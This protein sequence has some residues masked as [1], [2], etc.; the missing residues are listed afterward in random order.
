MHACSRFSLLPCAYM[1]AGM[2][3]RTVHASV[4][5]LVPLHKQKEA[6][7]F[8][9]QSCSVWDFRAFRASIIGPRTGLAVAPHMSSA[10]AGSGR[11]VHLSSPPHRPSHADTPQTTI[12]PSAA[13]TPTPPHPHHHRCC[14]FCCF[15]SFSAPARTAHAHNLALHKTPKAH[16]PEATAVAAAPRTLA[17]RRCRLGHPGPEATY[18]GPAA[19]C[20]C[21]QPARQARWQVSRRPR[22]DRER[23]E[24]KGARHGW[25]IVQS[26]FQPL[27]PLLSASRESGQSVHMPTW[28]WVEGCGDVSAWVVRRGYTRGGQR[29]LCVQWPAMRGLLAAWDGSEHPVSL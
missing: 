6:T 9:W 20:L 11:S 3:S 4:S 29:R 5:L 23:R 21:R 26:E 10:C 16:G 22:R 2:P 19:L 12:H 18:Q 28:P 17:R 27:L 25:V 1:H 8:C 24:R 7:R 15:C 14:C 13:S